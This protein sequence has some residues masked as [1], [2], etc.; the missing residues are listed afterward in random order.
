MILPSSTQILAGR[1][2]MRIALTLIVIPSTLKTI[3]GAKSGDINTA[4]SRTA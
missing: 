1:K 2:R 3:V 4:I